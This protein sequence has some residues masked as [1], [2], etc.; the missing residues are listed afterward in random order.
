MNAGTAAAELAGRL[1]WALR[2]LPGVTGVAA[3]TGDGELLAASD[4]GAGPR[5]A[6]LA[7]FL[8]CRG[9][10][11]TSDGDLRGIGR[12][13]AVSHLEHVTVAGPRS[14][15]VVLIQG[16]WRIALQCAKGMAGSVADSARTAVQGYTWQALDGRGLP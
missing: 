4:E 11:L 10:A 8:A 2:D 6:A 5:E 15:F 12:L 3:C 1:V 16:P 9:E 14:E 7:A 13:L